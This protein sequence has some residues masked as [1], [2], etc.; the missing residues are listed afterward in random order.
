MGDILK[1]VM[2]KPNHVR[3]KGSVEVWRTQD[4]G[5]ERGG[6]GVSSLLERE[7]WIGG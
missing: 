5:P 4:H 6:G 2:C 7:G 1:E 3:E